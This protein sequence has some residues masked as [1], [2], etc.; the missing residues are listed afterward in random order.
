MALTFTL[1]HRVYVT[2][3][4]QFICFVFKAVQTV[5]EREVGYKASSGLAHYNLLSIK[6]WF[7]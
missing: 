6:L 1:E 5:M 3:D 4:G 2:V 7:R